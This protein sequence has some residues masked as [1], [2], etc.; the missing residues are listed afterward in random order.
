MARYI[1]KNI[2]AAGLADRCLVQIGYAFGISEPV[3]FDIETFGTGKV[4][5]EK[6]ERVVKEL[7]PLKPLEIIEYLDLRRPIYSQTAVYGQFGKEKLPW[8]KTDKAQELR[9]LFSV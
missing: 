9:E 3:A 6:L 8:E 4:D 1:A 2:V 5:K 7:F